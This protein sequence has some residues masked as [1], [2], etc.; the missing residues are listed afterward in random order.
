MDLR[1]Y[2]I[3]PVLR[4]MAVRRLFP[5]L[6]GLGS[7]LALAPDGVAVEPVNQP[8]TGGYSSASEAGVP[9]GNRRAVNNKLRRATELYYQESY[10][11]A[12]PIFQ[13][14]AAQVDTI[15]VRLWYGRAAYGSGETDTAIEQ[16]Q[17]ILKRNPDLVEVRL[18]L[19]LAH[20]QAGNIEK[21]RWE[22]DKA[23]AGKPPPALLDKIDLVI[24]RLKRA[25]QRLFTSLRASAGVKGD[26]NVNAVP[27]WR[28]RGAWSKP[29]WMFCMTL[30]NGVVLFGEIR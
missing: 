1:S 5:C 20:I 10:R 2:H 7:W 16:F 3:A 12:L 15:D 23:R 28:V 6:L 9:P 11:L 18:D 19:A 29:T 17:A 8:E 27:S 26:N 25:D 30:A 24:K 14:V 22:L 13:D 4:M 21:A